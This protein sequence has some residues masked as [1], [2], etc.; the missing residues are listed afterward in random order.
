MKKIVTL[1]SAALMLLAGTSAFAQM[2]VGAGYVNS[3]DIVKI[4]KLSNDSKTTTTG[5]A[6]NG[7]YA[8]ISYTAP[9]A[10]GF[11]FTPGVYYE[12]L[13]AETVAGDSAFAVGG[14]ETE[15]YINVPLTFGYGFDLS[16]DLRFI[17]F[18]GP[19]VNVGLASSTKVSASSSLI[20]VKLDGG[21]YNNYD[22]EDY[23][24]FDIML[25][26]GIGL[27]FRDDFRLTVG[28]DFGMLNRYTGSAD[29]SQ[30]RNRLTAGIAFLF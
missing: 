8:G 20:G 26:G 25:G 28:Y 13:T 7:F 17:A 5:T 14:R 6:G 10:A 1:L 11:S 30:H 9:L 4:A 18:A 15:H 29:I 16:R 22:N 12:F 23:G 19:T 24:R 21:V 3:T 2:S 27:E